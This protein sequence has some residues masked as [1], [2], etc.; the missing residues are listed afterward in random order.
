MA[1]FFIGRHLKHNDLQPSSYK[2]HYMIDA[3]I[4]ILNQS[5]LART[6]FLF[7]AWLGVWEAGRI[8]EYTDHASVW[9][10]ASGFTFACMLVLGKRAFLPIMLGAIVITL[11][12]GHIYQSQLSQLELSW[13]GFLFGLAHIFP[14]WLGAKLVAHISSKTH[15][16]TPQLIVGFLIIAGVSA[17]ITTILVI[18][19]LVFT[20]QMSSDNV[21]KTLLPFWIGDL[22]GIVVLTPLFCGILIKLFPMTHFSLKEFTSE[23]LGPNKRL[24]HKLS[25][26]FLIIIVTMLTAY[27][28]DS[29]ESAFAIFFL[30]VTHMWIA[31][32]E[33]PK[34]NVISLATSSIMIIILVHYFKL[35]D[36]VMVYQFA[37]N[38]I[39]ANALFGIAIPQLQAHNKTLQ[40]MVFTD[41]LTQVSSR[42]YMNQ[43]AQLEIAQSLER[44]IPLTLVIFDLDSFKIINDQHGHAMGDKILQNV[45]KTAK[46]LLRRNDVIARFGGDEF[47]ILL[48][49]LNQIDA[50][51]V[52]E[53]IRQHIIKNSDQLVTVYASFG[54]AELQVEE[55][56]TALF[57]RADHALYQSKE[58]GGNQISVNA[59]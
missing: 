10:P 36:Y 24:L 16:N 28:F 29:K 42:H 57:K 58:L 56:F 34:F 11:W 39:A 51:A 59:S 1:A 13:A 47:V 17:L 25:I 15:S 37:I 5:S 27:W 19:S 50:Q 3:L 45:A 53:R 7:I 30:A 23:Q 33:S 38:V 9:F 32:T 48:P 21:A 46:S 41:S 35:M 40:E 6:F 43:R 52:L 26:N 54:V 8:V 4:K 55:D 44:G 18:Y 2:S 12:Q 14:Y 49:G 22:A 20:D 31:C